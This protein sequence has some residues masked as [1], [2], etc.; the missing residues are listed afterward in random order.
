MW[1]LKQDMDN[2][3]L[4]KAK[5][6]SINY[7]ERKNVKIILLQKIIFNEFFVMWKICTLPKFIIMYI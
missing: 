6:K 3:A 7:D 1:L 5:E 4:I 2:K